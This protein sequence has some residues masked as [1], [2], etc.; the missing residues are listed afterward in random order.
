MGQPSSSPTIRSTSNSSALRRDDRVSLARHAPSLMLTRRQD[1]G[2]EGLLCSGSHMPPELRAQRRQLVRAPRVPSGS[3][4]RGLP[5]NERRQRRRLRACP[6]PPT[7]RRVGTGFNPLLEVRQ[8]ALQ[9]VRVSG[10]AVAAKHFDRLL[11]DLVCAGSVVA[12][13]RDLGTKIDGIGTAPITEHGPDRPPVL[14]IDPLTNL[15]RNPIVLALG[16]RT[17]TAVG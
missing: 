5:M 2:G 16:S 13:S 11:S 9:S 4:P 15:R 7:T 17:P 12:E 1:A 14:C 3:A 10:V 6:R 8:L